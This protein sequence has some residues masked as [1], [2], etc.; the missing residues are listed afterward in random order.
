[1]R[2]N[3]GTRLPASEL[4]KITADDIRS[5]IERLRAGETPDRF[6]DSSRFDLLTDLTRLPPEAVVA[7]AAERTLGRVLAPDEFSG[8]ETSTAFRVLLSGGFD[9]VTKRSAL[10]AFDATFSVGRNTSGIFLIFESK[11]PERNTQYIEGLLAVL[12]GLADADASITAIHVD[13]EQTK[14]LPPAE[15]LL[16]PEQYSYPIDLGNVREIVELRRAVTRSAALTARHPDATRGGNPTKRLRIELSFLE[17]PSLIDLQH[18]LSGAVVA[19][20]RELGTFEFVAQSPSGQGG[21]AHRSAQAS[22]TANLLHDE[23]QM[24]LYETLVERYG[25]DSVAA[26]LRNCGPRAAGRQ[27]S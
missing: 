15:T 16:H 19:E 11:G 21:Q 23:M 3:M 8:G 6:I 24:E 10:E 1:M 12:G 27:I 7:L 25:R 20:N 14:A 2:K 13:S 22:S 5:A 17:E 4:Y 18:S 9:I 26:E